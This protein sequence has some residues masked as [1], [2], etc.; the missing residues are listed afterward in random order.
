MGERHEQ[1]RH[2]ANSVILPTFEPAI[3]WGRL[4]KWTD[5]ADP[6]F[7][8]DVV[9]N[10]EKFSTSPFDQFALGL[11]ERDNGTLSKAYY[12]LTLAAARAHPDARRLRDQ[13][14][15]T[16]Q[17]R[18]AAMQRFRQALTFG[19]GD[20]NFLLG[21]ML[22][23]D[24]AFDLARL[25]DVTRCDK[26]EVVRTE[27]TWPPCEDNFRLPGAAKLPWPNDLLAESLSINESYRA[28]ARA[29]QCFHAEA[30]LWLNAMENSGWVDQVTAQALRAQASNEV[31]NGGKREEFCNGKIWFEQPDQSKK[32]SPGEDPTGYCAIEPGDGALK[33]QRDRPGRAGAN[34]ADDAEEAPLCPAGAA[35][36]ADSAAALAAADEARV[37]LRMGDAVLAAGDVDYA[38][39]FYRAAIA[40]GRKYGAQASI[41]AGDRLRA[42]SLTCEYTTKSLARIARGQP[43]SDYINIVDRQ[44]A[45]TAL[46]YYQGSADGKWGEQTRESVRT[47]QRD[48][49]F[50]E[51]GALSP[52]ETVVLICQ[53]AEGKGDV[54][55]Q[56]LLGVMY[57]AGLGV[58]QNTDLALEWLNSAAR[59]GSADAYYN[60]AII[61]ST[62]TILSSYR[63]CDGRF[64]DELAEAFHNDAR[65]LRHPRASNE[66]F[67]AFKQRVINEA[68]TNL[69][70]VTSTSCGEP[71]VTPVTG[72]NQ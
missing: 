45:L 20:A 6:V 3:D 51:T 4:P 48:L 32:K 14:N 47:F 38:F 8:R 43:G 16:P 42:L 66:T 50:D 19:G 31:Q 26:Q 71:R 5:A 59:R 11:H 56:A 54:T 58:V 65:R 7:M 64:N 53:A 18:K 62:G 28:L 46:G 22:L 2:I 41:A 61:Y 25:P 17:D 12:Y 49:G 1:E 67:A 9:A 40:R 27:P 60:L 52:L 44:R 70:T 13:I 39:Q 30:P 29:A 69:E 34:P 33:A 72:D 24:G 15:I 63:L 35:G 36:C 23:G 21:M 68:N 10:A 37:C 55:S 57:A